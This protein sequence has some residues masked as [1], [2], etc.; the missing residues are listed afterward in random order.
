MFSIG[1]P[2]L[3]SRI[4]EINNLSVDNVGC[5]HLLQPAMLFNQIFVT[6]FTNFSLLLQREEPSTNI[7]RLNN[8]CFSTCD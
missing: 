6:N 1:L 5:Y 4:S 3:H 2:R 8:D 7:L